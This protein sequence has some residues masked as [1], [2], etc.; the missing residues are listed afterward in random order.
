[1]AWSNR[2]LYRVRCKTFALVLCGCW[3]LEGTAGSGCQKA[4]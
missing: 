1:V 4:L 3:V 2:I